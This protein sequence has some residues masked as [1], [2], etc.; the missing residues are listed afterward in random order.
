MTLVTMRNL[1]IQRLAALMLG[2]VLLAQSG[3]YPAA[4]ALAEKASGTHRVDVKWSHQHATVS[5]RHSD[6]TLL[7]HH[8]VAEHLLLLNASDGSHP[9]HILSA[10]A[11]QAKSGAPSFDLDRTDVLVAELVLPSF[12]NAELDSARREYA[13]NTADARCPR[14]TEVLRTVCLLV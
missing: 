6:S 8:G 5:L 4:V 7:H 10:D 12:E 11:P 13:L 3:V 14:Q 1:F 9:D 2:V